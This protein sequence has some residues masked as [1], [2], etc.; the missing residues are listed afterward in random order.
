MLTF[1]GQKRKTRHRHIR[2]RSWPLGAAYSWLMDVSLTNAAIIYKDAGHPEFSN[3]DAKAMVVSE[4]VELIGSV[5]SIPLPVSITTP[6]Q[7]L[8]HRHVL[9][10]QQLQ[11]VAICLNR[12]LPVL[13]AAQVQRDR[14]DS[15]LPHFNH[16][17]PI[18]GRCPLH[19][20]RRRTHCHCSHCGVPLH[21]GIC[22][23]IFHS[24]LDLRGVT[25]D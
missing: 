18:H 13:D 25:F 11:E 9:T 1:S 8:A 21:S 5:N 22:H 3:C 7:Q 10:D 16:Q 15:T 12:P 6:R 2:T 4:L 20:S 17:Y 24:V 23:D 14:L 19:S